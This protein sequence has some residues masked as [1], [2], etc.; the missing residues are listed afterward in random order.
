MASDASPSLTRGYTSSLPREEGGDSL[1]RREQFPGRCATR[2]IASSHET[3]TAGSGGGRV[4]ISRSLGSSRTRHPSLRQGAV[5]ERRRG[6]WGL[7]RTV[8]VLGAYGF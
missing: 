5:L 2:F 3:D 7:M 6:H 8:L 1:T 4:V